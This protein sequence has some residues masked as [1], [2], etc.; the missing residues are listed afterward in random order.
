MHRSPGG[1]VGSLRRSNQGLVPRTRLA[2]IQEESKYYKARDQSVRRILVVSILMCLALI[3][4]YHIIT[5]AF[6]LSFSITETQTKLSTAEPSTD[7]G[8]FPPHP[9]LLRRTRPDDFY[10]HA[11]HT[12]QQQQQ[13]HLHLQQQQHEEQPLSRQERIEKAIQNLKE[14]QADSDA[15]KADYQQEVKAELEEELQRHQKL[16]QLGLKV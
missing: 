4:V 3:G 7:E 13:L 1:S 10:F 5:A 2:Q 14:Y 8:I 16:Q 15:R 6:R 12:H 11:H 9:A